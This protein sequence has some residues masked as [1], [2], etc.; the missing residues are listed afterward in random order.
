MLEDWAGWYYPGL[1]RKDRPALDVLLAEMI[2]V[3][4]GAGEDD[5]QRPETPAER[6]ARL[7]G[8]KS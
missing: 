6:K 4:H 3:A 5:P 7:R 2:E 8:R 1:D